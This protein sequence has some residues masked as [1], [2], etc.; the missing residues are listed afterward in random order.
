MNR[1]LTGLVALIGLAL[2]CPA[3]ADVLHLRQGGSIATASWWVEGDTLYYESAAGTIGLPRGEVV[4][5]ERSEIPDAD[6]RPAPPASPSRTVPRPSP[7]DELAGA[8]AD[9][10]AALNA[11]DF[12][13]ASSVFLAILGDHP[14]IGEARVG[15]ALSEIALD[16]DGLALSIVLEGLVRDPSD[17][18]LHELHGDLMDRDERVEDAVRAW[19]EAFRLEPN[20]RVREKILKGE[21]ELAAGRDYAFSTSPHFNVRYG[22]GMDPR[23]AEEIVDL[24]EERYWQLSS[25]LRHGPDQPITVLLYPMQEFRDVTR[26]AEW[27]GG[28]YDGK[29]RV[30]LGGIDRIDPRAEAVLVHELT[31][32]FVHSKTRG[33]CPRWLHEGLAQRFEGRHD[34][35]RNRREVLEILDGIEPHSWD[36]ERF[37]YPAALSLVVHLEKRRGLDGIIHVLD[38][39]GEG[40]DVDTALRAVYAEDYPAVCRR[41]AAAVQASGRP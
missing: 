41:W 25:E 20:D 29:I 22:D 31:H 39:L 38:R 1:C 27:V 6:D 28:V 35:A 12:R 37:S 33:S 2:A 13:T 24:L 19:R 40:D 5:I 7:S 15:Y 36:A 3:S 4:R 16:R 8:M 23:L 30:P 34:S 32:A 10:V 11:R 18:R 26:S 21:R 9:G 14:E 17:P